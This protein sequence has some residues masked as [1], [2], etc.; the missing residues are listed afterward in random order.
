MGVERRLAAILATDVVGYTRLMEEDEAGTLA[1]LKNHRAELIDPTIAEQKG[2]IVKLI[3]DGMLAEFPSVVAAVECAVTIQRTMSERN[4]EVPEDRQIRLRVG[5]NL[6]DVIVD[7]DDIYGDGVNVAARLESLADPGGIC[8]SER[9][10]EDVHGKLDCGFE[11]LG[12]QQVKNIER[13]IPAYRVLMDADAGTTRRVRPKTRGRRTVAFAVLAAAVVVVAGLGTWLALMQAREPPPEATL[14][15]G[16]A[17]PDRPSIAILPF[18]NMSGDPEQEYF[19]DGMTEDLI[20]DL[21]KVSGL[22][23]IARNSSFAY[24]GRSVD[25]REVGRELGVRYILEG[26]IR[27]VGGSVRINAQLIDSTTGGHI[28]AERFDRDIEDVFAL[29]DEV[30]QQIVSALAVTLNPEEQQR[31][32]RKNKIDPKA[33]DLFLRGL[34]RLRRFTPETNVEARAF[35]H[36][37][38][39]VDPRFARAVSNIGFTYAMDVFIGG[40]VDRDEN[41]R[42]AERYAEAAVKLDDTVPAVLFGISFIYERLQRFDEAVETAQ[43]AVELDTNYADGYA[44]LAA[45]LIQAGRAQEGLEAIQTAMRLNPQRPSF[46][47]DILARAHF[48]DGRYEEAVELYAQVAEVNPGFMSAHRGLA[49]SYAHLGRIE[50]AEWEAAEIL[51]LQPDFSLKK[52]EAINTFKRKEDMDRYIEGLRKAGLPE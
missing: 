10:F 32:E 39:M 37:A 18:N 50:D 42:L 38:M 43:R 21:S 17:L 20:T 9:V 51:A 22:F 27:K 35:F 33:Y 45:A 41:L 23:V 13:P 16:L 26:S 25:L 3:G 48:M 52:E 15:S 7:E 14:Q 40:D 29:Q 19:S 6:G 8:I 28:W 31:F 47:L 30:T 44:Q 49:A 11:Y 24:K 12:E 36:E 34:E 4:A 1:V 2:R 5:I 46:Y